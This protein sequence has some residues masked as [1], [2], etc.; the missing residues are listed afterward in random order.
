[1]YLFNGS[2]KM[3][4]F[5]HMGNPD[6]IYL[7]YFVLGIVGLIILNYWWEKWKLRKNK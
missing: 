6:T 1:M 5:T 7:I 2:E 3:T 4:N